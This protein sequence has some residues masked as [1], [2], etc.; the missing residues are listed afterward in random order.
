[1]HK[2]ADIK[3]DQLSKIEGHADLD[4]KIRKGEVKSAKLKI[5]ENKR[6]YTQAIRGKP[7][8][9]IFQVT[10]RICGTCS[11]AHTTCCI[12]TVENALKVNPSPQ[13]LLLRNLNMFGLMVRD[14]ALHLYLFA[15]PDIFGVDSALEFKGKQ[16]KYLHDAF[17]VKAA[18]N[19]LCTKVAGR[20]VHPT[21]PLVGGFA[22][23]PTKE[24][25]KESVK[26]LNGIR[27]KVLDLIEVFRKCDFRL[28]TD[29]N[30]V[31]L[32]GDKYNF[33]KGDI[34][35]SGGQV[36]PETGFWQHLERVIIP[37]SQATGFEFEGDEY[38][39]GALSRMNLNKSN[40]HKN[41]QRD[42]AKA[43][44]IFP[45]K[46][47]FRNNLAQA[48]EI[49]HSIDSSVEIMETNEFKPE[50]PISFKPK[51]ASGV[52][53]VEAPRGTLYYMLS[54]DGKGLIKYGNLVIPTAQN[55]INM[56]KDIKKLIPPILH[57]P[58][59]YVEWEIEKL[60]RAY[61]PC[62]SCAAHFLKV[63]WI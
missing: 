49:L 51:V 39:V 5:T 44:K 38:V 35:T 45:S 55:Q 22:K 32:C 41:T 53:V 47:T 61:D 4:I 21:L 48:I 10:S 46:N 52:G 40:L 29:A 27:D 20:P 18:G 14:H 8:S 6:F 37:Y 34:H 31:G 30:F 28:D 63:K 12:E 54:I 26:K 2:T 24:E 58:K 1:M 50:A 25:M 33:I 9:N 62:M 7:A 36:I 59:A 3:I 60:I 16:H 56:E 11:T 43:L 17:D 57:K 15:M 13:T 23:I 42:A 19:Y